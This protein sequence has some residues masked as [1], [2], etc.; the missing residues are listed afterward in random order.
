MAAEQKGWGAIA[1]LATPL[2][3]PLLMS[4]LHTCLKLFFVHT[5]QHVAVVLNRHSSGCHINIM[6]LTYR[7]DAWSVWEAVLKWD[8]V[9]IPV[10]ILNYMTWIVICMKFYCLGLML[11]NTK[12]AYLQKPQLIPCSSW[13][14]NETCE[15]VKR[16]I[17]IQWLGNIMLSI[18]GSNKNRIPGMETFWR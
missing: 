17:S 16:K 11:W 7:G 8:A 1:P 15:E 4:C 9:I 5:I 3:P 6:R 14:D 18:Y 10:F 13:R 12:A 2:D